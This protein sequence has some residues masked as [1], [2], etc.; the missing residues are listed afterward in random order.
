MADGYNIGEEFF[1]EEEISDT[2]EQ[3]ETK[4]RPNATYNRRKYIIATSDSDTSSDIESTKTYKCFEY[5]YSKTAI[6]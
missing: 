5:I 1:S 4:Y 6:K 3:L 2:V